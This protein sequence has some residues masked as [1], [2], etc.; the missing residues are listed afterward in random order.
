MWIVWC[1]L[2]D[3]YLSKLFSLEEEL[4]SLL[5]QIE[6]SGS[7]SCPQPSNLCYQ[8]YNNLGNILTEAV[9]TT[10]RASGVPSRTSTHTSPNSATILSIGGT[11]RDFHVHQP[12]ERYQNTNSSGVGFPYISSISTRPHPTSKGSY[13]DSADF[14]VLAVSDRTL[15]GCRDGRSL[16]N[17]EVAESSPAP[18]PT[19]IK[20]NVD[21]CLLPSEPIPSLDIS[22][23]RSR[24]PRGHEHRP[25]LHSET[26][27]RRSDGIDGDIPASGA[28]DLPI[29]PA[30]SDSSDVPASRDTSQAAVS[31]VTVPNSSGTSAADSQWS[32]PSSNQQ[33]GMQVPHPSKA[34]QTYNLSPAAANLYR[35]FSALYHASTARAHTY[36]DAYRTYTLLSRG[37]ALIDPIVADALT[38]DDEDDIH[39]AIHTFFIDSAR[40]L[41]ADAD[42]ARTLADAANA[43]NAVLALHKS[44]S[45]RVKPPE[46]KPAAPGAET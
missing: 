31:A 23:P 38:S 25:S 26:T 22:R 1:F 43:A 32:S 42:T 21:S 45:T 40:S 44:E 3:P 8:D 6:V 24:D 19:G 13:N 4:S 29:K 46:I 14:S 9:N 37:D 17:R 5:K 2:A 30:T 7:P 20:E 27:F 28:K 39:D 41:T 15:T 34:N 33:N 12:T 35:A 16:G 36:P 18:R 10:E 11:S